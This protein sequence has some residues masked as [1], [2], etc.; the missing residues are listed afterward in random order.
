MQQRAPGA[1]QSHDEERAPDGLV[2]D[3]GVPLPVRLEPQAGGQ[4][5]GDVR[6]RGD[7]PEEREAPFVVEGPEE[8]TQRLA[9]ALVTEARDAGLAAGGIQKPPLVQR[10][11]LDAGT[12]EPLADDDSGPGARC[13][14]MRT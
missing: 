7:P 9:E 4:E 12:L 13:E 3:A 11:E 2:G 10:D 6:A 1:R 14:A 5:I 8:K